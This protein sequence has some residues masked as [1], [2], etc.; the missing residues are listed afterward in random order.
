[1]EVININMDFD[2]NRENY[3]AAAIFSVLDNLAEGYKVHYYLT[4]LGDFPI[5]NIEKVLEHFA[6]KVD[7]YNRVNIYD[8]LE[9]TTEK[10]IEYD[11]EKNSNIPITIISRLYLY[12][13]YPGI[14]RSLTM[15][16]DTVTI[17]SIHKYWTANPSAHIFGVEN[18]GTTL[19][20]ET[21]IVFGGCWILDWKW[22]KEN[23]CAEKIYE[24]FHTLKIH[25]DDQLLCRTFPKEVKF[26]KSR[27]FNQVIFSYWEE[28][29]FKKVP[30]VTYH[31][32][33]KRKPWSSDATNLAKFW[34][35]NYR[36]YEAMLN[37]EEYYEEDDKCN[38]GLRRWAW[39]I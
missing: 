31:F 38:D 5:T 3:T 16:D 21:P 15:D 28:I 2:S 22:Y 6:D 19:A 11:P 37:G 17:D 7:G 10:V 9:T 32:A 34:K 20:F 24:S 13:I 1:M 18:R 27:G 36:K 33:G 4:T 30:T 39:R 12:D 23:N 25:Y 8:W 35:T 14:G 29:I 26:A